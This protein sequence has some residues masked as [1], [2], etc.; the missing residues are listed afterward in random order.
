MELSIQEK[1]AIINQYLKTIVSNIYSYN[2][3][4]I[5]ENS[6]GSPDQQAI[7]NINNA[8]LKEEDKKEALLAEYATLDLE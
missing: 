6:V 7:I 1:K 3:N 5:A 8:I 4:L 2:I